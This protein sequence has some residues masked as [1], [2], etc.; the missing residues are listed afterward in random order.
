MENQTKKKMFRFVIW[1][2]WLKYDPELYLKII[3]I[4][5]YFIQMQ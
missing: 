2:V 1:V 5:E 3:Y 4:E